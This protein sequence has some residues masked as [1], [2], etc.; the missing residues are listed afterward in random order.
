MFKK[1]LWHRCFPVNFE[2]FLRA[3]F[4][5]LTEHL[6][7]TASVCFILAF[8]ALLDNYESSTGVAETVTLEEEREN[9]NFINLIFETELMKLTHKFLVRKGKVSQDEGEFKKQF[10][11]MWFKLYRKQASSKYVLWYCY[12]DYWLLC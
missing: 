6:R 12:K 9:W 1:S 11:D 2:N 5:F 10:Y 8:I 3:P 7:A 4:T